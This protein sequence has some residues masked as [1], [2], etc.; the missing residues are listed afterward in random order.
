MYKDLKMSM[1]TNIRLVRSGIDLKVKVRRYKL[2]GRSLTK[3]EVQRLC[4]IL[5]RENIPAVPFLKNKEWNSILT[6]SRFHIPRKSFVVDDWVIKIEPTDLEFTLSLNEDG[7][8]MIAD[9]YKRALLIQLKRSTDMWTLD[10]PRIFYERDPFLKN[11]FVNKFRNVTDI[12]GYRRFEI[13]DVFVDGAGLGFSINVSTAF[14]TSLSVEDYFSSGYTN[15]FKKLAGRQNEQKGTLIY[16]GPKGP[17][18]CYFEKYSYDVTL[19]T[20]PELIVADR[21][22][23]NL[24]EYYQLT[25]PEYPVKPTDRAAIVSFPG[26]DKKSYVPANKLYLRVM[27]DALD[28][29][30]S[31]RDKIDPSE[32]TRLLNK[33]WNNLG[34]YPFGQFFNGISRVYYRPNETN[35][36]R[37]D[38]PA[39]LF[40]SGARL[41]PPTVATASSYKRHFN[42]RRTYLE[43]NGCFYTPHTYS[44]DIYFVYPGHV[45]EQLSELYAADVCAKIEKLTGLVLEPVIKLYTNYEDLLE[46]LK[47]DHEAAMIVFTFDENDPATYFHIRHELHDWQ[48]KRL[49]SF[50]LKKTYRNYMDY[51]DGKKQNNKAERDWNAFVE[52]NTYDIIQQLGCLPY[53]VEPTLTYDMQLIIDVSEKSSHIALSLF[54]YKEGMKYPVSD[55][56]IKTKTDRK[57]EEISKVFLE[58]YLKDL[59]FQNKDIIRKNKM[60]SLLVLRD[61]KDCGEE[62]EAIKTTINFFK[63]KGIFTTDFKFDFIEYHKSSLKEVRIWEKQGGQNVNVLEGSYFLMDSTT[64]ILTTTGAGT[65]HQGTASPIMIKSK[66]RDCDLLP[67]LRDV[68]ISSQPNY[69]SPRVAQRLTYSAKRAD[70]Q[71]KDR[72]AQEVYRIK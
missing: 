67:I 68:F 23:A 72:V 24:Y 65:L 56:L 48:L 19:A 11:D 2:V 28:Y 53:V 16:D 57:K 59:V 14:F 66:H 70:E 26:L 60:N 51:K 33:F 7:T 63:E 20:T 54:M 8:Q 18:K 21:R 69:S 61:G 5:S 25:A 37:F 10:S 29:E 34:E 55:S 47:Y 52:Q 71:L 62:Y 38:L 6:V 49:T 32:R 27:N 1:E 13:S 39:L 50:T 30:M 15:R 42:D 46:E 64:A 41:T 43:R 44:R 35:S 45:G 17:S 4:A 36:G 58:K 40:G 9:L 22:F 3:Q 12:E 31:K